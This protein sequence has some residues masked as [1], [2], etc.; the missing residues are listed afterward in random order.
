MRKTEAK[1]VRIVTASSE[2]GNGSYTKGCRGPLETEKSKIGDSP[3]DLEKA[4][5]L[6]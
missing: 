4:T 3:L 6:Y 1:K 5:E 2:N